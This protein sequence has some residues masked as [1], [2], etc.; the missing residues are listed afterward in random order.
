ML[1]LSPKQLPFCSMAVTDLHINEIKME[2]SLK[3]FITGLKMHNATICYRQIRVMWINVQTITQ[4][5]FISQKLKN[6]L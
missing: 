1:A 6:K 3:G 2:T 4:F 5:N